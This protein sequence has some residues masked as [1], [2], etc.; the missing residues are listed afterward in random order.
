MAPDAERYAESIGFPGVEI[1]SAGYFPEIGR[2]S[3]TFARA[4]AAEFGVDLTSHQSIIVSK[5][6]LDRVDV[7]F[8][9]DEKNL[10]HLRNFHA[11]VEVETKLL[12]YLLED[13]QVSIE[14]P[15]AQE[16]TVYRQTYR[17]I[18]D[19][20]DRLHKVTTDTVSAAGN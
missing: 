10:F 14:D 7:V 2:Q 16:K 15:F 17:R 12:G 3:P 20:I 13:T 18:K 19:A 4:V 5:E 6:M 9:F 8:V 1:S 11:P